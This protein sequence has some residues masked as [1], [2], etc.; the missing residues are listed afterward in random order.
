MIV[1]SIIFWR[2]R[3][4]VKGWWWGEMQPTQPWGMN[5]W[6]KKKTFTTNGAKASSSCPSARFAF[7]S[8]RRGRLL[9]RRHKLSSRSI[10]LPRAHALSSSSFAS[11]STCRTSQSLQWTTLQSY[12]FSRPPRFSSSPSFLLLPP[13]L[14]L[15]LLSHQLFTTKPL[16]PPFPPPTFTPI[17][18]SQVSIIF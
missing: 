9:T 13:L 7:V 18:H 12:G 1:N 11:S 17:C 6:I 16:H 8:N 14:L 4:S 3:R 2:S 15:L 5:I 10:A